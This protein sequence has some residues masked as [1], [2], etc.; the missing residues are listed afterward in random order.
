MNVDKVVG[1]VGGQAIIIH[2]GLLELLPLVDRSQFLFVLS[3]VW[4]NWLYVYIIIIDF[5]TN[6]ASLLIIIIVLSILSLNLIIEI[7]ID[8]YYM[9]YILK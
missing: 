3:R 7:G 8:N 6:L 5:D 9:V 4:L 1:G 2:G